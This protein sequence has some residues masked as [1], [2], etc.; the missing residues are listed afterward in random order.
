MNCYLFAQLPQQRLRRR[1]KAKIDIEQIMQ[2]LGYTN[3]GRSQTRY[4]GVVS[5]FMATLASMAAA[6]F[7]I[8][9]GDV[10]VLQYP[11]KS[12]SGCSAA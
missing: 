8:G 1:N 5:A 4:S 11:L 10:L 9:R 7:H 6:P 2:N 3:I 12:T